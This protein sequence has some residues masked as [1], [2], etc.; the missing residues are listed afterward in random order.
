MDDANLALGTLEHNLEEAKALTLKEAV[1]AIAGLT[2]KDSG[3]EQYIADILT[4][5]KLF[6]T[7]TP[8]SVADIL[9]TDPNWYKQ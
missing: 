5:L 8:E 3:F 9:D 1:L 4:T 7:V 2:T 6:G